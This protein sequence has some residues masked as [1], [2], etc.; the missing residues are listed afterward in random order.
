M[1]NHH[2]ESLTTY[3]KPGPTREQEQVDEEMMSMQMQALR[4]TNSLA[5]PMVFKA[6]L[7]GAWR[8]PYDCCP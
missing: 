1:T 6:A 4:I 5:F 3:P 2:Q 8:P 7:I